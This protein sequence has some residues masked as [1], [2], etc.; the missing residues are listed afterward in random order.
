MHNRKTF[1]RLVEDQLNPVDRALERLETSFQ[2]TP[3]TAEELTIRW[4]NRDAE[5]AKSRL[6]MDPEKAESIRQARMAEANRLPIVRERGRMFARAKSWVPPVHAD[7]GSL[8]D[9]I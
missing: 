1:N 6:P 5:Y 2:P 8:R 4:T 9:Y 3:D 7:Y